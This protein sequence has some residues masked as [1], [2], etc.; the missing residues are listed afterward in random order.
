M[1]TSLLLMLV[2]TQWPQP[3][4]VEA[5]FNPPEKSS[6]ENG[7]TKEEEISIVARDHH[8]RID[9]SGYPNHEK[10]IS[11]TAQ[12]VGLI[13]CYEALT[14]DDRPY[15]NAMGGFHTFNQILKQEV[16]KNRFSSDIYTQ[17]VRSLEGTK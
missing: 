1:R 10:D 4:A 11:P 7:L 14:N 13:D 8:E 9:G 17:F 5:E 15:R 3:P 2:V 16:I 6:L 12:I